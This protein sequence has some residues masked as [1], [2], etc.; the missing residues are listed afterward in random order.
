MNAI[1][2]ERFLIT[3][4]SVILLASFS[5]CNKEASLLAADVLISLE[6]DLS[7]VE[8][9]ALVTLKVRLDP[10][11]KHSDYLFFHLTARGTATPGEDYDSL[12]GRYFVLGPDESEGNLS[13]MI[14][15]DD[16][17]EGDE[18][19]T[20]GLDF[21]DIPFGAGAQTSQTFTIVDDT[22]AV[23]LSIELQ[24]DVA[25]EGGDPARVLFSLSK[26]NNTGAPIRIPY[27]T[28]GTAV[29]GTDFVDVNGYAEI[30]HGEQ[31]ALVVF[32]ANPDALTEGDEQFCITESASLPY[33]IYRPADGL[34]CVTVEDAD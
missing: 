14:N 22:P 7:S 27:T 9:G 16:L 4:L 1:K 21:R 23:E 6:S 12:D 18:T 19:L 5:A 15:G 31:E 28:S 13:F 30:A 34:L 11:V 8:E 20:L 3:I 10:P 26:V 29:A 33:G 32:F 17:L 2:A 25:T 24:D